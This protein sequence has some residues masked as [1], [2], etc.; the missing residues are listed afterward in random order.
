METQTSRTEEKLQ[1]YHCGDEVSN[2][3]YIV[4]EHHFCCLACQ[5]V[6]QLL[7]S[8]KLNGYYSYNPHP[9]RST[10]NNSGDLSYLDEENIVNQL[11]DFKDDDC[12][13]ITLYVP[14]IHCSS[15]IWLLE[16][17][18]KINANILS[19]RADFMKRR[20]RIRFNYQQLSLKQLIALMDS[21]GYLPQITLQ[22]V[23]K[24][25]RKNDQYQLIRKI[26]VAGFCFGNS[27]MMSFPEYFGMGSFEATY[28]R[29][30]GWVNL[31]F[32]LIAMLYSGRSYF[33]SSLKS[34]KQG[35]L[36][37]DV[38]LALGIAMLF[39][40]SAFEIIWNTGPGFS[41]TLCGLLF[42]LLI[43]KWIQR[44]TYDNLSFERDYKSYFPI[45]VTRILGGQEKAIALADLAVGDRIL[46]RNQEI[47]PADAILLKGEAQIDFSF[48]TGE[49]FPVEKVLGEVI[50]AGG[51]QM[52]GAIE[53]EVVKSVSQSYLTSL[54][55]Q[56]IFSKPSSFTSFSNTVSRYFTPVLLGIAFFSASFWILS[57]DYTKAWRAFTAVLIIGCPCALA[58]SSPFTLSGIL[59]VFDKNGFYMKHTLAIEKMATVDTIVFDKTGTITNPLDH[60]LAFQGKLSELDQL[61]V[62]SVCRNSNH[63]ISRAIANSLPPFYRAPLAI[64][65][66]EEIPGKGI[67]ATADGN[68]VFIG[69]PHF[70]GLGTGQPIGTYIQLNGKVK[71]YYSI[72]QHWRPALP[73]VVQQLKETY[74]LHLISGDGC[75]DQHLLHDLFPSG[76]P[77]YFNQL[78]ADKLHYIQALQQ[79]GK[80]V[81]MVGD[82][83]NDAGALKQATI[84]IAV[85]DDIN[86]FS[87][88]SDGILSGTSFLLLPTFF[89]L[90]KQAM[91]IIYSSFCISLIY[92]IIG[93]YFAISGNMSPLFAAILMPLS[94]ITIISFT[95][96]A[97]YYCAFKNNMKR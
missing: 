60:K 44:K 80:K 15:C 74:S 47:I 70:L 41:D 32:G 84:G 87:P 77:L 12:M 92:N 67:R 13:I 95:R 66:Y 68:E 1:C 37:L 51:R 71:G 85:S 97:V 59:S 22:D 55:N 56:P 73:N 49:A 43:G 88:A 25:E 16:N 24:S 76:T 33:S 79:N 40:R 45:A 82:G 9:G 96:L 5:S 90:A 26:A 31:S 46:I 21:I 58:L 8:N 11:I 17:L 65:A 75:S 10:K 89:R 52:A 6:Y 20:V 23:V 63:P 48:V 7:N 27:M 72:A 81:A 36:S 91:K 62:F 50:Y 42:F 78:P 35:R 57:G 83:L 34:I 28:A 69:T 39:I 30:F 64:S 38:P 93:L 61:L 14:Q 2:T 3:Y 86:N 19:S 94:T 53:L 4:D 18:H 54:W 29:L